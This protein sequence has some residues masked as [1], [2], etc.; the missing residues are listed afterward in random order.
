MTVPT[1]R[2]LIVAFGEMEND[3]LRPLAQYITGIMLDGPDSLDS[4][5]ANRLLSALEKLN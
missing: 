4:A 3:Y 5:L 1:V 2:N